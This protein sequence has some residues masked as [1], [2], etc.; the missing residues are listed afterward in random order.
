M[1]Y[2]PKLQEA[3]NYIMNGEDTKALPLMQEII[4]Y[5]ESDDSY[6][7]TDDKTPVAFD[8]DF[9]YILYAA[10]HDVDSI[11]WIH[12]PV[13]LVYVFDAELHMN[14]GDYDAA[15][16]ALEK[17]LKWNPISAKA[18]LAMAEAYAAK[19]DDEKFHELTLASFPNIF[20]S[21]EM[22]QAYRNLGY[23]FT[24]KD[25]V[26]PAISCF[27]LSMLYEQTNEAIQGLSTLRN[28]HSDEKVHM[29]ADDELEQIAKQYNIPLS[30]DPTVLTTLYVQV[31]A[32]KAAGNEKQA[33][34]FMEIVYDLKQGEAF[35]KYEQ[36]NNKEEN[37]DSS[38]EK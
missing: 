25:E 14:L 37:K 9:E 30:P 12:E 32:A 19:Q 23:Y 13:S 33:K 17:A 21:E 2:M 10:T 5:I 26:M 36:A 27:G 38:E 20:H 6:K 8:E 7:Q 3:M 18:Q 34:Q 15:I 1:N 11:R 35:Y 31:Q 28:R 29:P 22:G 16:E 24:S 4:A